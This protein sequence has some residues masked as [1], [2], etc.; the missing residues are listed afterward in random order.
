MVWRW[1]CRWA[2]EALE[3]LRFLV[4]NELAIA[5]PNDDHSTNVYYVCSTYN[6]LADIANFHLFFLISQ[7]SY[8]ATNHR[9]PI[10][11]S[12]PLL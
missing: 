2:W 1:A 6:K 7:C 9:P 10:G 5:L 3:V 4:N 12:L 11:L 8:E